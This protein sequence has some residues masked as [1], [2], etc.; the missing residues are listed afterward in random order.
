VTFDDAVE[1]ARAKRADAI[2][3]ADERA[4]AQERERESGRRELTALVAEAW[5]VLSESGQPLA[6]EVVVSYPK[7]GLPRRAV[8]RYTAGRA[9]RLLG[10]S[11]VAITGQLELVRVTL[12]SDEGI[13][14]AKFRVPAGQRV[15]VVTGSAE[16]VESPSSYADDFYVRDGVLVYG[17]AENPYPR[18]ASEVFAQW[19]AESLD[20]T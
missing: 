18:P 11:G 14:K 15:A 16:L 2:A 4:A 7:R 20:R 17:Y 9:L 10:S 8:V 19:V 3:R 5:R 13:R 1:A 12:P 6:L